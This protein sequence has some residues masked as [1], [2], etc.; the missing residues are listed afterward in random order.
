VGKPNIDFDLVALWQ[1]LHILKKKTM[2]CK[3][4]MKS[5]V[6]FLRPD[7]EESFKESYEVKFVRTVKINSFF[8]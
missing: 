4:V 1:K 7:V 8:D 5:P 2:R 3:Q 6:F